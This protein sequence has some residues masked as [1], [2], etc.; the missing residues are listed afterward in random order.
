MEHT[1]LQP[2][3]LAIAACCLAGVTVAAAVNGSARV[4]GAG[5]IGALAGIALYHASF[6]FTSA[7]R[8]IVIERRGAGLRA[9]MLLIAATA[10]VSIPLIAH[11]DAIGLATHGFVFPF[12]LSAA[13]GAALFGLGMQLGGGCGS[14]TLYT[15]GGGSSRM[16]VTLAAFIVG[17]LLA[18]AHFPFW[19]ALPAV[20]PTSLITE[21]G[22]GAALALTL[23]L[24]GAIWLASVL[25]EKRRHGR[26]D[27]L[28]TTGSWLAGP[29]SMTAGALVL[30]AVGIATVVVVGRPWGITSGFALWGAKIADAAGIAVTDWPY[31]R[32]QADAIRRPVFADTTSVMN[33]GLLL[34]AMAAAALAGRFRPRARITATELATAIAGGL[35]M[36][37]GARLAFGCNIGGF[38]GGV[39]SASLHGWSWL[40]FGFLGSIAGTRLRQWIGM[41]S[42]AAA[43]QSAV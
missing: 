22:S 40:V 4:A 30:A 43:A 1:R 32:G 39:I 26:I 3:V 20:A 5:V 29:W 7:W 27:D 9:Q 25:I 10:V 18:T 16:M 17:S 11:G 35:M 24:A 21:F 28:R 13:I 42:R 23:A 37:Y 6:G 19:S 12:G 14:G 2:A 41:D 36:G 34:G 8:R 33:F 15:A 31:W 38:L